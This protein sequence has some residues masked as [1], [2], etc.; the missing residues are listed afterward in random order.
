M[1]RAFTAALIVA[2]LSLWGCASSAPPPRPNARPFDDVRRVVIVV[3]GE[4][5]F[6]IVDHPVE[7]GRT[8]DEV[9]KWITLLP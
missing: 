3:S 9:L 6:A 7:P 1:L 4:S 8:F 5:S 2:T